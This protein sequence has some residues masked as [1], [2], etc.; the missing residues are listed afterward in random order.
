MGGLGAKEQRPK[1]LGIVPLEHLR[2]GVGG[3]IRYATSTH[4]ESGSP[5][6]C[7]QYWDGSPQL[8]SPLEVPLLSR[9]T[10]LP[11]DSLVQNYSLPCPKDFPFFLTPR[12]HLPNRFLKYGRMSSLSPTAR[13]QAPAGERCRT[14]TQLPP[15]PSVP[16]A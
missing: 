13:S 5:M 4:S 14:R 8:L 6:G 11:R 16:E 7:P 3:Y 1:N 12:T 9:A 15:A 10:L 2:D